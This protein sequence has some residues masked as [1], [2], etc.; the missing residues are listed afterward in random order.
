MAITIRRSLLFVHGML[1]LGGCG[2]SVKKIPEP[3]EAPRPLE[4][5][6]LLALHDG[7]LDHT[8]ACV[9]ETL[10]EHVGVMEA[11]GKNDGPEVESYLRS[12]E[13]GKG[14]PWCAAFIHWSY[15]ECGRVLYPPRE[16]AMAQRFHPTT[17]RIWQKGKW[18]RDKD[19][20]EFISQPCDHFAIWYKNL[21]RIGHTGVIIDEDEKFFRTVEG[22]TNS[23]GG[24]EGNGVFIRY[25]LKKTTYC[26]SRWL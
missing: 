23:E 18:K 24:R 3:I 15:R 16:F 1:L 22:N 4:I 21:G 8:P 19:S 9:L 20:P 17:H 7:K 14:Y 25:R 26:V 2:H 10:I 11:T 13:L 5:G 12:V 6:G